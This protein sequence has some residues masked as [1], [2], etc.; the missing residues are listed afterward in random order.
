MANWTTDF[1]GGNGQIHRIHSSSDTW[2]VTFAAESRGGEPRPLWFY[3]RLN[4]LEPSTHRYVRLHILN[5]A[6]CMGDPLGW[7][8]NR[9]VYRAA[10]GAWQRSE[11][12][13]VQKQPDYTLDTVCRI[14][15]IASEMEVA[16]CYPYT[17]SDFQ[18]AI[19]QDT[20]AAVIGVTSHGRP[21]HRYILGHP[22][23]DTKG[24]YV[25]AR[26][27]SG[28]VTGSY[29][30]DGMIR[31]AREEPPSGS[32]WCVPFGDTD[33]VAEGL[34]GKDQRAGDFN[35]A[36]DWFFARRTET[37]AM[38]YDIEQFREA[39][40]PFWVLDLH[41][42][43]HDET[44][45]YFV[46]PFREDS[47]DRRLLR[48]LELCEEKRIGVFV[49]LSS[50]PV[51]G[52]PVQHPVTE[53]HPLKPP[54]VYHVT[55]HTQELLANY[56]SYTFGLRTV[57]LRICSPVGYGVNPKTIFPVFVRKA[58][59]GESITLF[60]QGTRKQ[61]YI[62]VKDI[63]KAIELCILSEA[64]GVYNL[65]SYNLISNRELAEKCVALLHSDSEIVYSGDVDPM[66]G[67][68]WDVSIEKLK[69]DTGFEPEVTI[70]EAILDLASEIMKRDK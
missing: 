44:S 50:L 18:Q 34:Y 10:D 48:L 53:E 38:F 66:E 32:L 70:D 54:T 49:Q 28:E 4:E 17:E 62:H 11:M 41:S 31:A 2:D 27:H 33:G 60:G 3:F 42:P 67:L 30:L 40:E 12:C 64:Q 37:A 5:A 43:G 7:T 35:R 21:I 1:A 61:T 24:L 58:M 69:K 13:T 39:T 20:S 59:A 25:I 29:L 63:A 56:A 57:S 55:K 47:K 68:C 22:S 8:N 16:F 45:S 51:I 46:T 14:P 23:R 19:G 65:A 6:Q 36:W 52:S 9:L 26:Q 15:C